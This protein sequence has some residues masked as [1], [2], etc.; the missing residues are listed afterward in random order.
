M[1][2]LLDN[3]QKG[4]KCTAQIASHQSELIREGNFTDQKSLSIIFLQTDYLN[5]DISS[6]S[7]RSNERENVVQT[8]CNF[9]GGSIHSAEKCF[10]RIRKDKEKYRAAGDL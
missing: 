8:E 1:R 6:G 3:F 5:L 9:C 7:G 4:G 2:I 10:K